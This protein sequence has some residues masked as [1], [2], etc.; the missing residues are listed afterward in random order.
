MS[1]AASGDTV[2]VHYTGTLADGSQFDS[3]VGGEPLELTLGGGG[4]I[5]GFEKA[6]VGMAEGDSR[7]VTIAAED[8][9]GPHHADRVHE[10][11]RARIPADINLE[12]GGV[13][14][15]VGERGETMVVKVVELS[16]SGVTLDFNHPLAGEDLTFELQLV[17]IV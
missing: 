14:Q 10:V 3:S 9:Y 13:L 12:V 7:T 8:A 16:D 11:E 17:E 15:A 5:P 6:V 4:V 2:K 1:E